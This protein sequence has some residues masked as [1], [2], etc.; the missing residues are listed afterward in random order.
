[1]SRQKYLAG[2]Q[3][4]FEATFNIDIVIGFPE[5]QSQNRGYREINHTRVL[6]SNF[7]M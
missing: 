3:S 7:Q 5:T 2:N 4:H 6:D 1:M